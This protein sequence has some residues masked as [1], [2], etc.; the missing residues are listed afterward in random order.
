MTVAENIFLGAEPRSAGVLVDRG[1]LL[2]QARSAMDRLGIALDPD[3][4]LGELTIAQQQLIEICK[5]AFALKLTAAGLRAIARGADE[6][7]ETAE[8]TSSSD[9]VGRP[10][11]TRSLRIA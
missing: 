4:R 7:Q 2:A 9:A 3:T 11:R 10:P 8:Q 6:Q 5:S 1:T